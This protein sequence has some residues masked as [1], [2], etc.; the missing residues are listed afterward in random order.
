[1]KCSQDFGTLQAVEKMPVGAFRDGIAIVVS[2]DNPSS[3]HVFN[4]CA[5][6]MGTALGGVEATPKIWDITA[7]WAIVQAAGGC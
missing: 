6:S 2:P 4:L 5:R 1:M 7:T 3:N